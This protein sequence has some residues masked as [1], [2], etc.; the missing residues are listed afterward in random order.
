MLHSPLSAA[1]NQAA[2]TELQPN[3]LIENIDEVVSVDAQELAVQEPASGG[4]L[5]QLDLSTFPPQIFWMAIIFLLSYLVMAGKALPDIGEILENRRSLVGGDLKKAEDL[6]HEA[7]TI[8]KDYEEKIHDAHQQA[9]AAIQA[10]ENEAAVRA[11][12]HAESFGQRLQYEICSTEERVG[13][14][15]TR[16]MADMSSIA[17][18][19]ASMAAQKITGMDTDPRKAQAIVETLAGNAKAA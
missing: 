9:L 2:H 8:Q 13:A 1:E 14:A 17:A 10:S 11:A 15:K 12:E 16:A 5:P 3:L 19:V 4:S 7:A 18:E 6:R